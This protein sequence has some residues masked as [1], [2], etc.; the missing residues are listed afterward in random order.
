MASRLTEFAK[1]GFPGGRILELG[2][3]TGHLTR[4]LLEDLPGDGVVATDLSPDMVAQARAGWTG[5]RSPS[6][7]VLDAREPKPGPG[8]EFALVASNALVQWFP[9]LESHF[10]ACR[11][12]TAAPGALAATGFAADH[13]P[14]LD[15]ILREDFGYPPGPGHELSEVGRAARAAGWDVATLVQ[16][17]WPRL[18]PTVEAFFKH[19]QDSGA[20]RPPPP[21]P[22]GRSGWRRLQRLLEERAGTPEGIRITWKPWF[23]TARTPG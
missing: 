10:R 9:D 11:L 16:E 17:D 3:G 18:Y 2:C 6:W 1:P 13:F 4:R 21:H 7:E 8:R 20:N 22:M 5:P 19:L 23:L 15:S 12:C 14:E